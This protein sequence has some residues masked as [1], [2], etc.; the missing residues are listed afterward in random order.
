MTRQTPIRARDV[1]P[2]WFRRAFIVVASPYLLLVVLSVG[3]ARGIGDLAQE[4]WWSACDAW[5]AP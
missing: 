5:R 3:A 4:M 2:R 1:R